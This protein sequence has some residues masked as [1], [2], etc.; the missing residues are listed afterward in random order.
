M[1]EHSIT[2]AYMPPC[3]FDG[4]ISINVGELPQA[5]PVEVIAGIGETIHCHW[6]W[7]AME[8]F[9]NPTI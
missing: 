7:L 3:I 6:M 1:N 8:N 5:K 4:W 2:F 9:S